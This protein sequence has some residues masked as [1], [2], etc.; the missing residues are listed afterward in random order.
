[1]EH[2][3]PSNDPDLECKYESE[4][5]SED[6]DVEDENEIV[7]VTIINAGLGKEGIQSGWIF[8]VSEAEIFSTRCHNTSRS[9]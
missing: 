8:S 3:L 9:L 1:M 5:N 2:S 4:E 7:P 6:D